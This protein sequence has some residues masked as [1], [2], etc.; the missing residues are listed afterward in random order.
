MF[1]SLSFLFA[2]LETH[3]KLVENKVV[4]SDFDIIPKQEERK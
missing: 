3:L 2:V 1:Q 4:N